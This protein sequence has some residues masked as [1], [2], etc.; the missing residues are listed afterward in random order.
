MIFKKLF[1]T[2]AMSAAIGIGLAIS[3]AG[4]MA[5]AYPNKPVKMIVGFTPGGTID[6][7]ARIIAEHLTSKLGQPF[8]VENR[9]GANGMIAAEAVANSPGDGYTI[10]VSNSSTITLNPSLFKD[11]RYNP[12]RDFAP[13]TTVVSVPLI[14]S[15]N[16]EDPAGGKLKTVKDLIDLAKSRP[17]DV[18]YGSA[19]NGNITH[20]GFELLSDR[21]GVKMLHVPYRGAAAAQVALLSKEVTVVLDTLSGVPHIKSGKMRALAVSSAQRLP[22]LP[23]VP[24]VAEQGYPGYDISFWVG[25]FLPKSTPEA[26]VT[27]LNKEIREATTVASVKSK[28]EPQG[29]ILTQSPADFAKKVADESTE[30][31]AIVKKANIKVDP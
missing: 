4:A 15:V 9:T 26:I 7:V 11:L 16:P 12:S 21:A 13:V 5:Q 31:A 28:L 6:V 8:I 19:G 18:A 24:T 20:M 25:I 17:G 14:L 30:L 22:A 1:S 10:F 23:D 3:A 29:T 2:A 27:L